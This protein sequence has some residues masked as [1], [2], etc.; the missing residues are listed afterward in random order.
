MNLLNYFSSHT[1]QHVSH[2]SVSV[3]LFSWC[4]SG[5]SSGTANLNEASSNT[6]A[7][8]VACRCLNAARP[9]VN[10]SPSP[11]TRDSS[12]ETWSM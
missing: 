7:A 12:E 10:A 3:K 1:N 6:T 8:R 4:L 5:V 2:S 11:R 9:G